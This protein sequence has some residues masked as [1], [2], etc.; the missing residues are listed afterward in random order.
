MTGVLRQGIVHVNHRRSPGV[1]LEWY[2]LA[3]RVIGKILYQSAVHSTQVCTVMGFACVVAP[4]R[5]TASCCVLVV[6]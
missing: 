2:R 1:K 3:G 4:H 5:V 6:V